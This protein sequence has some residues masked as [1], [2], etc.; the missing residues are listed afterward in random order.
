MKAKVTIFRGT[1]HEGTCSLI[2]SRTGQMSFA[3]AAVL[4]L[5]ISGASVAVYSQMGVRDHQASMSQETLLGLE[6]A[7][8]KAATEAEN[9]AYAIAL[10]KVKDGVRNETELMCR[11][12]SSLQKDS[13]SRYPCLS[14]PYSVRVN[15]SHL[16]LMFLRLP[17]R[18]L[19]PVV[20]FEY[21]ASTL[22]VPRSRYTF[23]W[24]GT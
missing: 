19:Y 3:I 23:P 14:G 22:P 10:E 4:V 6:Q 2:A 8:S 18:E 11:F 5:I 1:S 15:T 12:I 7:S 17:A 20:A 24:P 21:H 13:A 9:T 16:T